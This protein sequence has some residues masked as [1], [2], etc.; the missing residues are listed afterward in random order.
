MRVPVRADVCP[1]L[2]GIEQPVHGVFHRVK[3]PVLAPAWFL[4]RHP[5]EPRDLFAGDPAGRGGRRA[6]RCAD[7]MGLPGG[8][9][10]RAAPPDLRDGPPGRQHV[11]PRP[12]Q[13]AE[14]PEPAAELGQASS[15][16]RTRAT[17]R[18]R[19]RASHRG[20]RAGTPG[21]A[22]RRGFAER[23]TTSRPRARGQLV[24][25]G[26]ARPSSSQARRGAGARR[27]TTNP[28]GF[29]PRLPVNV[30]PPPRKPLASR[31][32]PA[33][34]R[35]AWRRS[36]RDVEVLSRIASR[37]SRIASRCRAGATHATGYCPSGAH[38]SGTGAD[39]CRR[40]D[41]NRWYR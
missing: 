7:P 19:G 13:R 25:T 27:G 16:R 3:I 26:R 21:C 30:S 8:R 36:G 6:H 10:R 24:E 39:D 9:G 15:V 38:W 18:G 20:G 37:R 35:R 29:A 31:V 2:D 23:G 34:R 4:A 17:L 5:R 32:P 14:A 12:G 1:R 28:R 33:E 40:L 22:A 11:R 41:A